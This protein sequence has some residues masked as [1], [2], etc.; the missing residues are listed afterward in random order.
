LKIGL[1]Q[2]PDEAKVGQV[3]KV[4][5]LARSHLSPDG[6]DLTRHA[7]HRLAADGYDSVADDAR[8]QNVATCRQ[9]VEDLTRHAIH[10]LAADGYDSV[11]ND[12]RS[13]NV[14]TCR[15]TVET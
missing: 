10:R 2:S 4:R 1:I 13:Q 6:G 7:I 9:T 15:Q 14:A 3:E 12:A 8:S 11:A 5:S